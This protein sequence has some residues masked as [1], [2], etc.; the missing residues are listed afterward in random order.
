MK[1]TIFMLLVVAA[2]VAGASEPMVTDRPDFTESSSTVPRGSIQIEVGFTH[3][4][5]DS[6]KVDS[7]GE[8]LVRWGVLEWL[9]IRLDLG[10]Y[11][12]AS[13]QQGRTSGFEDLGFGTKLALAPR[14]T[15]LGEAEAAL[16]L[17]FTAPT[18][19]RAHRAD[20]WQP[21]AVLAL[22]WDLPGPFSLGANLGMARLAEGGER[23][24]SVW[25]SAVI[26]AEIAERLGAFAELY[27]FHRERHGGPRTLTAQTGL[28][29]SVSENLQLD[30][31]LARR[32]TDEG[33]DRLAGVGLA[34]RM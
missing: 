23:F 6:A 10:S 4:R 8:V 7:L 31:R 18:G 32:L 5:A 24:T 2:S 28:T 11:T 1:R 15:W 12:R 17:A 21:K 19:S 33:P 3:E 16:I 13:S 22:G 30:L 29:W 34:Y 27:G 26:G 14:V 20:A 9:E 25:A